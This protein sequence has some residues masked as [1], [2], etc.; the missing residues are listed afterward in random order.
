MS[1]KVHWKCP[2]L[3]ATSEV[4][5]DENVPSYLQRQWR[6]IW[7]SSLFEKW[8]VGYRR[9]PCVLFG[10]VLLLSKLASLTQKNILLLSA[11]ACLWTHDLKCPLWWE[12]VH[13][14]ALNWNRI[15]LDHIHPNQEKWKMQLKIVKSDWL[16]KLVERTIN[17]VCIFVDIL[18]KTLCFKNTI[19]NSFYEKGHLQKTMPFVGYDLLLI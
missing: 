8:I 2:S 9:K 3:T 1:K 5:S 17:N 18:R 15:L 13:K 4:R 6:C 14:L 12:Q 11:L 10:N 16:W 19:I 7:T